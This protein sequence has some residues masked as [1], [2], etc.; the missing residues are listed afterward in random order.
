MIILKKIAFN[1]ILLIG[2]VTTFSSCYGQNK[3]HNSKVSKQSIDI[4]KLVT[5]IDS[6]IWSIYQDN[7]SNFWFGSR[8]NGV[9]YYDGKILKQITQLF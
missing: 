2:I 5:Q 4:G 8:E 6:T 9:F 1:L 3:S 7:E